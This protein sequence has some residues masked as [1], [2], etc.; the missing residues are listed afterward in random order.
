MKI[1]AQCCLGLLLIFISI[2]AAVICLVVCPHRF[3]A[4]HT[5]SGGPIFWGFDLDLS[6]RYAIPIL[7]C[8]SVGVFCLARSSRKPPKLP[9]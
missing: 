7:V 5:A 8:G 6:W 2:L 3:F 1:S 9:K 4:G